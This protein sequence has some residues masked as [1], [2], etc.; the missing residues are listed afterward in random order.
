VLLFCVLNHSDSLL[1]TRDLN[2][3]SFKHA[4]HNLHVSCHLQLSSLRVGKTGIGENQLLFARFGR[5]GEGRREAQSTDLLHC[6]VGLVALH[7]LRVQ[8]K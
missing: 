5:A 7:L 2:M 8:K 6:L 1:K 3:P 4:P